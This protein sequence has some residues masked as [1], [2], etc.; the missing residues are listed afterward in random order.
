DLSTSDGVEQVFEQ[1]KTADLPLEV[2]VN[3]AGVVHDNPIFSA[4]LEDFDRTINTNMRG[5]WFLTKRAARFM[6]RKKRGRIINISSVIG[7]M[8]NPGQSIYGM[9]KAALDNMTK[10][11]AMEL[12]HFGI[13]VN[14]VAPGYIETDMTKDI[15]AELKERMLSR[16]PLG[17]VGTPQEVADVVAFLATRA[18]YCTGAVFHVNGGMYCG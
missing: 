7:H 14:S 3:N 12:S 15:P 11:L 17:R 18:G 2:L 9:T 1:V 4:S 16:I 6:A 13:L 8:G 5:T 10:S